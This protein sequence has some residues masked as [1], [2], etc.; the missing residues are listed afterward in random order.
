MNKTIILA[1][2]IASTNTF[3][4]KKNFSLE[5]SYPLELSDGNSSGLTGIINSRIKYRFWDT[6]SFSI[7]TSYSIDL[8]TGDVTFEN[9]KE[10]FTSHH[11]NLFGEVPLNSSKTLL[12]SL[13]VGYSLQ[14]F[15]I[16]KSIFGQSGSVVSNTEKDN[17]GG[18]NINFGGAYHIFKNFF[19]Q[20]TFQ[21]MRLYVDDFLLEEKN[22]FNINRLKFGLGYR[23]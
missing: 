8:L 15:F 3:S 19:I 20:G 11:F 23:F 7:G 14:S 6:E 9:K 5:I 4:K 12:S 10:S 1:F 2:L 16:T 21:F 13:G 22:G 18:F 17:I